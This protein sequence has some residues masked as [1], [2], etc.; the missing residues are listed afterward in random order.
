[1]KAGVFGLSLHDE[2]A[3]GEIGFFIPLR[4]TPA[5][6]ERNKFLWAFR[7]KRRFGVSPDIHRRRRAVAARRRF[8]PTL[9]PTVCGRPAARSREGERDGKI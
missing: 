4:L 7:P 3:L 8:R 1:M 2:T 6:S 9:F 5:P